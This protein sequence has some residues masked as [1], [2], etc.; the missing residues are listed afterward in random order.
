DLCRRYVRGGRL[1]RR[2]DPVRADVLPA[3]LHLLQRRLPAAGTVASDP[4]RPARAPFDKGEDM[5]DWSVVRRALFGVLAG[6][7]LTAVACSSSDGEKGSGGGNDDGGSGNGDGSG[8]GNGNGN[9]EAD[10]GGD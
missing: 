4:R 5:S 10:A 2:R 1:R 3:D 9:G 7:A 8:N 6:A